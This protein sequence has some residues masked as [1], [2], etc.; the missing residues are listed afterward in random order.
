M[1]MIIIY[2]FRQKII[3]FIEDFFLYFFNKFLKILGFLIVPISMVLSQTPDQIND[4]LQILDDQQVQLQVLQQQLDEARQE[5]ISLTTQSE[6]NSNAIDATS[7]FVVSMNASSNRTETTIGG[8][9]ESHFT[10]RNSDDDDFSRSDLH[11]YVMYLNHRFSDSVSFYS[12][13]EIEHA[14]TDVGYSRVE[15]AYI[16]FA[17]GDNLFSAG[18]LLPPVGLLN[19]THEPSTFNTV[20][21]NHVEKYIIPTT[22][23]EIGLGWQRFFDNGVSMNTMI[24]SGLSVP[25]SGSSIMNIRRGRQHG[26]EAISSKPALT[27]NWSYTGMPGMTLSATYQLQTDIA[28]GQT[29]EAIQAQLLEAHGIYQQGKFGFTA[30]YAKWFL[31]QNNTLDTY[32]ETQHGWFIEPSYQMTPRVTLYARYDEV[33]PQASSQQFDAF[34]FGLKLIPLPGVSFKMGVS[35]LN[36]VSET[37]KGKDGPILD[38]GIGYEF[39]Q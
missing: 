24:H 20:E 25:I 9:G 22:W 23:S 35:D 15:Q 28:A 19:Q 31:D 37:N 14:T 32:D 33:R 17:H 18:L 8:Y 6:T 12:E 2:Q 26:G 38:L 11:R 16:D 29:S 10:R 27:S 34:T 30:L 3:N 21:R 5:I 1:V 39:N 7:D 4:I 13:M 36:Y